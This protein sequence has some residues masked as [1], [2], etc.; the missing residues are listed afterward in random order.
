M[1]GEIMKSRDQGSMLYGMVS[2]TNYNS[3]RRLCMQNFP[4]NYHWQGRPYNKVRANI[5]PKDWSITMTHRSYFSEA[6]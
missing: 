2:S 4:R 1:K 5:N 6:V 3:N